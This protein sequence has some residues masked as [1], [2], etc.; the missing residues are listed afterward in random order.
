M[1]L[2]LRNNPHRCLLR[3]RV[4]DVRR[5]RWDAGQRA[6]QH[7]PERVEKRHHVRARPRNRLHDLGEG[8]AHQRRPDD[9]GTL[10]VGPD[11]R[12]P[13]E[14]GR[15]LI[16]EKEVLVAER[17]AVSRHRVP[18]RRLPRV[19]GPVGKGL[20]R[21]AVAVECDQLAPG[22]VDD[23]QDQVLRLGVTDDWTE[24]AFGR[25]AVAAGGGGG[26]PSRVGGGPQLLQPVIL[27][28]RQ[29]IVGT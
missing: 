5:Q 22:K 17:V 11:R 28:R 20:D 13:V 15:R 7:L 16:R 25:D 8:F 24:E 1:A 23:A 10:G 3:H 2:P 12:H 14:H 18:D 21:C 9:G 26:D 4:P 19:A 27:Q 6:G 29:P